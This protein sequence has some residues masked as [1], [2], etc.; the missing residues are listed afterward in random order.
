MY[1]YIKGLLVEINPTYVVV[2]NHGIGYKIEI[3]LQTYTS[4]QSKINTVV[5]LF[6][7]QIIREDTHLLF[8]FSDVKER[9]LFRML[10]S[11]S[12]IGANTARTML[13]ASSSTEIEENI[14]N[15]NVASLKNI[16]GIG[17]KTAERLIVELRDK[18]GKTTANDEIF[19]PTHNRI[20]EEALSAL[21]MLGYSKNMTEKVLDKILRSNP[22]ISTEN[23]IKQALKQL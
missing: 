16:K 21:S 6:L 18:I 8:G 12:G 7:H 9:D 15:A 11:V 20:K 13:S 10:I 5:Q 19:T 3:S 17:Q 2:E 23:L 22:D 14:R 4:V 1:E